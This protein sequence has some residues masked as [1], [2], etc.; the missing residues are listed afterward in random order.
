MLRP[1]AGIIEPGRDR[2]AV[3]DLPVGILQE[4]GAVAVQHAGLAG[5][6]RS[7]ML[8]AVEPAPARLDA[9]DFY[10]AVVEE[11]MKQADGVGAAAD[12]GDDSVGQPAFL[13]QYLGA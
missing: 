3:E 7:A 8:D 11:W 12:G 6:H 5:V 13:L 4:I 2:V 1:D 10:R 9:D